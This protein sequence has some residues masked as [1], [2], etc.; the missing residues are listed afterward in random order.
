MIYSY[1]MDHA[2]VQ[3]QACHC[4][5]AY[6][7]PDKIHDKTA[8]EDS[9]GLRFACRQLQEEASPYIDSHT[10]L[11][12]YTDLLDLPTR[13]PIRQT[14]NTQDLVFRIYNTHFFERHQE[15]EILV[16][17][18][19]RDFHRFP[20]LRC[21]ELQ[22]PASL[23]ADSRYLGVMQ[24]VLSTFRSQWKEKTNTQLCIAIN[25]L[26]S[27]WTLNE[28]GILIRSG[29]NLTLEDDTLLPR[30]DSMERRDS[31]PSLVTVCPT[32]AHRQGLISRPPTP[33]GERKD[34]VRIYSQ[35]VREAPQARCPLFK[36]IVYSVLGACSKGAKDGKTPVAK[37]QG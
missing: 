36:R 14:V 5:P 2:T 34:T 7:P 15:A 6:R 26:L 1:A 13:I 37:K 16:V 21:I 9:S 17:Q 12:W 23:N 20:A 30:S 24:T 22:F 28:E 10:H 3:P 33:P 25:S 4:A 18:F 27:F 19:L 32:A 29:N 11:T 31:W 35:S 8:R